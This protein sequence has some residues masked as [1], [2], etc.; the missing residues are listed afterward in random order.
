M[1]TMFVNTIHYFFCVSG[2]KKKS[3]T[4]HMSSSPPVLIWPKTSEVQ[5]FICFFRKWPQR[6]FE[7]WLL[8]WVNHI[9]PCLCREWVPEPSECFWAYKGHLVFV[10]FSLPSRYMS[11]SVGLTGRGTLAGSIQSDLSCCAAI[12]II[13]NF[14]PGKFLGPAHTEEPG[15]LVK[16]KAQCYRST[17]VMDMTSMLLVYH[18]KYYF[19]N[20]RLSNSTSFQSLY[21]TVVNLLR[22]LFLISVLFQNHSLQL[23]AQQLQHLLSC[24]LQAMFLFTHANTNTFESVWS[25]HNFADLF[26][27]CIHF[28]WPTMPAISSSSRQKCYLRFFCN[29]PNTI[30]SFFLLDRWT[31][32]QSRHLLKWNSTFYI[33]KSEFWF[34]IR[35]L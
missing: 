33:R 7:S 17:A 22:C 24:L 34:Y 11:T 12:F 1:A 26:Y 5:S 32:K 20:C 10:P 4:I 29:S 31:I 21:V 28:S 25:I 8:W 14:Q 16:I 3:P 15:T 27:P 9:P 2:R 6:Q 13:A 19:F 18:K 23:R 35:K 30:L